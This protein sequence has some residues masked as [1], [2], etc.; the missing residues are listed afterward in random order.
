MADAGRIFLGREREAGGLSF[1]S[2]AAHA[3][4]F[5]LFARFAKASGVGRMERIDSQLVQAYGR[6]LASQVQAGEVSAA[7]AQNRVSSVNT[8]LSLATASNW[9]SVSPT[10]DCGIQ[11]RSHVRSTA[12]TGF[13]R[14]ALAQA[15]DALNPRGQSFCSLAR[16]FGLRTKEAALLDC[17]KALRDAEKHGQVRITFGTKGGMA[18]TVPITSEAQIETLREAAHA[19]GDAK[20]LIPQEVSWAA[21]Q[22]GEM[23][24]FREH[25]QTHGIEKLHDLRAAYAC[26]RYAELTGVAAPVFGQPNP[27]RQADLAARQVIAAELGHGRVDVLASYVGGRK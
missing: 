8:V 24:Q 18:R 1:E 25:L 26:Q 3:D 6:T 5:D 15:T 23:R 12:P 19:Q 7:T 16:D 17:K 9:R 14:A 21:F 4:R 22:A 10:K 27:N 20:N 13:D 11:E 2:V